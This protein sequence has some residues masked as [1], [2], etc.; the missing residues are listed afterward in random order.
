M[1]LAGIQVARK[2]A[3]SNVSLTLS[4]SL[5][6]IVIKTKYSP[7]HLLLFVSFSVQGKTE[8][9][10]LQIVYVIPIQLSG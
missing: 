9:G 5:V 10:Y 2:L 7:I 6:V 1:S 8:G 4:N 3:M